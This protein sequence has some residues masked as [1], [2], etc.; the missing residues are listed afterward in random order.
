MPV[1]SGPEAASAIRA[2]PHKNAKTIPI[3][4]VTANAYQ[5]DIQKCLDAGMNSHLSKPIDM[6]TLLKTIAEF[7]H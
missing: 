4:A 1:M 5:E 2:L 6:N 3:I 7:V